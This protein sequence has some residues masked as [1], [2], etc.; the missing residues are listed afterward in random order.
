MS[1]RK[2][3]V[4]SLGCPKARV[5]TEVM[6]GLMGEAGYDLT[7]DA[8][9][10]DALVVNTCSFLKSAVDESV[11]HIL[12][13]A[14]VKA[15]GGQKLVVTGCLPSRYGQELVKEL[16]EVDTFLGT[17]DIHRIGEALQGSLPE[18][19][20]I[21]M[22]RSHLYDGIDDGRIT[23]TRG[24]SAFLKLAEGCNRTCTFCIIPSI[25]GKQRSRPIDTVVTEARR[26]AG[27]GIREL[28]LVAQDLTSYGTDFRNKRALVEL[29]DE[30][31]GVD[32][33][34]WIRLMYA[35][36]WNFT[37][38]L[39][40]RIDSSSKVLRYVDMPLQ[41]INARILKDM[42]RNIQR[43]AQRRLLS[44]LRE[45]EGMVIRTT[46]IA[47]FPGETDAEFEE[48]LDWV[49]EVRFDRVGVFPYSEEPGTPAGARTDQVPVA[50]REERAARIM[51]RQQEIHYDKMAGLL[52]EELEVL[53]DGTSD[54]H[55][56]VLEGR[57]YG[58]APEI[59]GTV[60]LSI[61]DPSLEVAPGDLVKARVTAHA[62]YDL[63]ASVG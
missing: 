1:R 8:E 7:D 10:A 52:G 4:V 6:I 54:E 16:P 37:D 18:R 41:H 43:D 50:V 62:D 32:G 59:D 38:E 30:L 29:L 55:E 11:D 17:S 13:L 47:G 21:Q 26:L 15:A 53:V 49:G 3:H 63:V 46:F 36:P 51:E 44:R 2:V 58:Q 57:Y 28:V 9:D 12:E 34:D 14:Q 5:D 27:H 60:L 48:L 42:R 61:E 19:S 24:A 35:Y 33:I 22:G 39:L 40:E 45:V 20:Y 31:E 23:T 25:R 56:W